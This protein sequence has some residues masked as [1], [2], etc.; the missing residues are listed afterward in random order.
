MAQRTKIN[1]MKNALTTL[2]ILFSLFSFGQLDLDIA[3]INGDAKISFPEKPNE[4]VWIGETNTEGLFR[5]RLYSED[6]I[7][8][9]TGYGDKYSFLLIPSKGQYK[10]SMM[11]NVKKGY[12][13]LT[14]KGKTAKI[15]ANEAIEIEFTN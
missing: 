4:I 10:R 3:V 15:K 8:I 5:Q 13:I 12:V 1:N 2:A 14:C 7:L 6:E 11:I 9:E